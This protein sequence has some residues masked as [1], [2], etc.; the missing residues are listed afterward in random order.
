MTQD[1]LYNMTSAS[2]RAYEVCPRPGWP[3]NLD[4]VS[5]LDRTAMD[6]F[7]SSWTMWRKEDEVSPSHAGSLVN[8]EVSWSYWE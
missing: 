6:K 2:A 5:V 7:I 1:S 8:Q 4:V 3:N